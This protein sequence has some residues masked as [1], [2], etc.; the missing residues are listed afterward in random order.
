VLP[1]MMSGRAMLEVIPM[2]ASVSRSTAASSGKSQQS[3]EAH[4]LATPHPLNRP[5]KVRVPHRGWRRCAGPSPTMDC[6]DH[7]A[8]ITLHDGRAIQPEV[9][10]DPPQAFLDTAIDVGGPQLGESSPRDPISMSQSRDGPAAQASTRFRR[11]VC[12]RSPARSNACS[13]IT[14]TAPT[15]DHQ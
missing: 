1:F 8:A 4:E 6:L 7:T 11:P 5:R 14:V 13:P 15:M 9:L 3:R 12:T 2:R 10:P